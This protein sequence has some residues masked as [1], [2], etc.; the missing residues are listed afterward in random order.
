VQHDALYHPPVSHAPVCSGLT[1]EDI[2][3]TAKQTQETPEVSWR[4][5]SIERSLRAAR[6]KA[7]SRSDR[8]LQTATE[9]LDE[10]GRIDFTIQEL[11]ERS[12]TS[13][14]SFYQHFGSKDELMLALF[15]EILTQNVARWRAEVADSEDPLA[16]LHLLVE[17][18]FG[19]TGKDVGL[20]INRALTVY[21]LQLAETRSSEY[22]RVLLPL[23]ELILELIT[24]GVARGLIRETNAVSR[25]GNIR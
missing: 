11:I 25:S 6:A 23:R 3:S 20:G 13:L 22:A 21:H 1:A 12:K 24:V 9:I 17:K 7:V 5:R 8:F 15:E 4:D 19:R 10:T 16:G 14:R 2:V 18:T